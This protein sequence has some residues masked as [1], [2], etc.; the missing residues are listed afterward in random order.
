MQEAV[1]D[2]LSHETALHDTFMDKHRSLFV[3]RKGLMKQVLKTLREAPTGLH[4]L[5]GK[6]GSGKSAFLVWFEPFINI[7]PFYLFNI[8]NIT[9]LPVS[10]LWDIHDK[11]VP[12]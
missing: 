5:H 2:E 1:L 8:Y 3:G 4:V 12:S 9:F 10:E 7:Y 6:A 11:V